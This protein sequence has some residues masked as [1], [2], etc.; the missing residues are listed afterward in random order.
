KHHL[1]LEEPKKLRPPP[2]RQLLPE[3]ASGTCF[4]GL[5]SSLRA[6]PALC[7]CRLPAN[8]NWTRS[9]SGSPPCAFRMSGALW[10]TSTPCTSPTV[11]SMACTTSNS[12]RC[13]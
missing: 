13:L 9:W 8:R 2:A 1:G 6:S 10:S 11:T 7:A 3:L 5:L 12:A 4:M